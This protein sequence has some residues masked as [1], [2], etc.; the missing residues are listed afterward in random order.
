[1]EW[2]DAFRGQTIGLDTSPFIFFIEEHPDY[3]PVVLPLFHAI[4][5]ERVKAVTSTITLLE[6]L[7]HP[8][9]QGNAKLSQQYQTILTQARGIKMLTVTPDIAQRAAKVRA[10][11][12]TRTPD[13][14]QIAAA[15]SVGATT[16][17][18]NDRGFLRFPNI[19]IVLLADLVQST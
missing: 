14:I 2:I 19:Q 18:T 12:G 5:A 11:F 15:L 1:M 17:I 6:V 4:H 7:V 16:F 3:L 10:D 8:L 9:R 13:S